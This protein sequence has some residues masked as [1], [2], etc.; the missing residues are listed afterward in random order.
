MGTLQ[1]IASFST[2]LYELFN[3]FYYFISC[4]RNNNIPAIWPIRIQNFCILIGQ[5]HVNQSQISAIS[6]V[7]LSEIECKKVKLK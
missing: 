4:L 3:F 1:I 7:Q 5:E 6:S 2:K